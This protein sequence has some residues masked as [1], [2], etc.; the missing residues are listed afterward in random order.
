MCVVWMN[1][2]IENASHYLIPKGI[3]EFLGVR[4]GKGPI[5]VHFH[6]N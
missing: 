6:F 4:L 5:N 2:A 1:K 3:D